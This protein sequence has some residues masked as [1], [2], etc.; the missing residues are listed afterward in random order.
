MRI[1]P[2]QKKPRLCLRS[3]YQGLGLAVCHEVRCLSFS[4]GADYICSMRE[5]RLE[6]HGDRTG[7]QDGD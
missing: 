2:G 5:D 6:D 3:D 4:F 1:Q 7:G